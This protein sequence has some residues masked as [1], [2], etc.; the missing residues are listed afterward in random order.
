[1]KGWIEKSQYQEIQRIMPIPCVDLLVV[2]QGRLLLMLR[3]DEPAKNHWFTPGGRILKNEKIDEAAK[4]VLLTETGLT[5]VKIERKGVMSHIYPN[6]HTVT[7]FYLVEVDSNCIILD[8]QH[9]DYKWITDND[10][11]LHPFVKHMIKESNI[12]HDEGEY[13]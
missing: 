10:E 5:P 4:R 2:N 11:T 12:F 1:M 6:I 13:N 9:S 3:K 8:E 7:V